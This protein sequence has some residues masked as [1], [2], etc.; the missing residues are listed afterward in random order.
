M[1]FLR[2]L[3][4]KVEVKKEEINCL[5]ETKKTE[6]VS[7]VK[8][9]KFLFG[10]AIGSTISFGVVAA[11]LVMMPTKNP[12]GTIEKY[13]LYSAKP[14]VLAES[15]ET[16]Q[17]EDS[18]AVKIDNIFRD[19]KCPLEGMGSVFV[20]EADRNDIP[21][22]IVAAISFQESGCGKKI[23]IVD[24]ESSY[25]AWGYAVYGGNVH[26]FDNWAEGVETM[27]RYLRKRFFAQGVTDPHEIM[28]V[29]TP[30]SK[31][32]WAK[33]VNYFGDLIQNYTSE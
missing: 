4:P 12:A 24:G 30:P 19:Y 14:L 18:R 20:R 10:W 15:T 17:V 23:P 28:S 31:G 8:K 29:Y 1:R 21:W 25:N 22:W 7:R 33:G 6:A 16:I 13:T 2:W 27:S 26:T 9:N 3:K 32:S 5:L 11:V